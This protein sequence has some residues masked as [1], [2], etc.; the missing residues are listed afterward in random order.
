MLTASGWAPAKIMGEVSSTL[1]R[2][3]QLGGVYRGEVIAA[4]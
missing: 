4:A 3:E 2:C 1:K